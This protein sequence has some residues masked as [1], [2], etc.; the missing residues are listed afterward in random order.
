[1]LLLVHEITRTTQQLPRNHHSFQEN[2]AKFFKFSWHRML[3]L[4]HEITRTTQ[5]LPRNHHSFQENSKNNYEK[6]KTKNNI[7]NEHC[8]PL[9]RRKPK[10]K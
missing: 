2:S 5:Q 8:Q 10:K 6:G 4:V 3:L 1:M 7:M 9:K